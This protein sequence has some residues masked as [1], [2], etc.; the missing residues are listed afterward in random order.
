[1]VPASNWPDSLAYLFFAAVGLAGLIIGAV[2]GGVLSA[3]LGQRWPL[4]FTPLWGV[5]AVACYVY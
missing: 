5:I 3:I 4:Y 1:M 2:I